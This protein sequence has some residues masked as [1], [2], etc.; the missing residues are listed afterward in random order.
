[1]VQFDKT[2]Q[3]TYFGGLNPIPLIA[4]EQN[5]PSHFG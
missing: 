3:T 2:S 4:V 5:V 1:M